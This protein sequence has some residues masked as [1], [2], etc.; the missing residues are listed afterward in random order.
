MNKFR[1]YGRTVQLHRWRV[2]YEQDGEPVTECYPTEAE[3]DAAVQRTGGAKTS[4]DVT[5]DEWI[6]GMQVADVPQPMTEAL[7]I[8]NEGQ[9]ALIRKQRN[10]ALAETDWT[11]LA[12]APFSEEDQAAIRAYRQSLRDIPQQEGFPCEYVFP[13]VPQALSKGV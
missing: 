4:I 11:Q 5:G 10:A 9:A 1:M 8:Y 12:D 7:R 6:D 3:A 2:D 13:A